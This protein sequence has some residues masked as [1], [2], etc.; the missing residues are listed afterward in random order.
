M[1]ASPMAVQESIK[2]RQDT[3]KVD[4]TKALDGNFY[5]ADFKI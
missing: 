3:N 2:V 1:G 4:M 5:S